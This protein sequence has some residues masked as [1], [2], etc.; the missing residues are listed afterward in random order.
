MGN[1]MNARCTTICMLYG[2][3]NAGGKA[4]PATYKGQSENGQDV[5]DLKVLPD[6]ILLRSNRSCWTEKWN[7][8]ATLQLP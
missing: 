8:R 3:I 7:P 2:L 1:S 6:A 5:Y 4:L